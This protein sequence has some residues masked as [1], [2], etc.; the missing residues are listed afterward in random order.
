VQYMESFV[1]KEGNLCIIMEFCQGGDLYQRLKK[2]RGKRFSEKAP[3]TLGTGDCTA[4]A[5]LTLL[6]C[7][8]L[9]RQMVL[10]WFV[11]ICLALHYL[12]EAPALPISPRV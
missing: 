6:T 2:Q 11:Q 10:D 3:H 12:H 1:D 4:T 8:V 7:A 5:T 9:V